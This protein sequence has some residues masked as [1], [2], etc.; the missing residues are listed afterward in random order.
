VR[1][2]NFASG[3]NKVVMGEYTTPTCRLSDEDFMD[4]VEEKV[5]TEVETLVD[6][7]QEDYQ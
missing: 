1:D 4:L 7:E 2:G 3:A 6:L 5:D